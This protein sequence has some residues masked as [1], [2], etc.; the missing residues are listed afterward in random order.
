M[1]N[2]SI[3]FRDAH[4]AVGGDGVADSANWP[5][6]HL[7]A[8]ELIQSWA[9]GDRTSRRRMQKLASPGSQAAVGEPRAAT[10]IG[11]LQEVKA[12]SLNKRWAAP[13]HTPFN[14]KRADAATGGGLR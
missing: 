4:K 3:R 2:Y 9:A 7:A 8:L 5:Q 12:G 13:S 1:R 14:G 6:S 11:V 10:L